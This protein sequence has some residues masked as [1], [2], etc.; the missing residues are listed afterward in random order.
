VK[1]AGTNFV[2]GQCYSYN[3]TSGTLKVGNWSGGAFN[4]FVEDSAMNS[5]SSSIANGG[6]RDV[7]GVANGTIYFEVDVPS[8]NSVT[9]QVDNW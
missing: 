2:E 6:F 8:G 4:I 1:A 3:K 9:A 7:G 5:V